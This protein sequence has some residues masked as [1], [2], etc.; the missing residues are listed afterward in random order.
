MKRNKKNNEVFEKKLAIFLKTIGNN[1][2]AL[3]TA[4][5]ENLQTVA[6]VVKISPARLD[7]IEKGLCPHC[8]LLSL[9]RLC[10]YYK[11]NLLDVVSDKK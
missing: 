2:Y 5:N 3:R 7:K 10:K 8:R 4:R 11:I 6:K 1:L 9:V